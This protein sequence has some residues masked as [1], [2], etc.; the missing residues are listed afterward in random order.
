MGKPPFFYTFKN[1]L[2]YCV[3]K[4]H[5]FNFN[6][7]KALFILRP[8]LSLI[9]VASYRKSILMWRIDTNFKIYS[10]LRHMVYL[11]IMNQSIWIDTRHALIWY[12]NNFFQIFSVGRRFFW[13]YWWLYLH[14]ITC[15]PTYFTYLWEDNFKN[16][17]LNWKS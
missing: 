5:K 14:F 15:N 10:S 13:Q 1:K 4:I 7:Q 6:S 11:F 16:M 12:A 2:S 3:V 17:L 8:S 9:F